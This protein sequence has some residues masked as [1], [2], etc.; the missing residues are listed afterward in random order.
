MSQHQAADM[1][2]VRLKWYTTFEGSYLIASGRWP[3]IDP[4]LTIPMPMDRKQSHFSRELELY[5]NLKGSHQ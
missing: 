5:F 3:S 4:E 1:Q 2:L